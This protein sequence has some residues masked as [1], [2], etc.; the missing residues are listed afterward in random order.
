LN[1]F[2][3]LSLTQH[4]SLASSSM[5]LRLRE[6]MTVCTSALILSAY[7]MVGSNIPFKLSTSAFATENCLLQALVVSSAAECRDTITVVVH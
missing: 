1:K 5:F 3:V 7:V 4:A 6:G 2:A